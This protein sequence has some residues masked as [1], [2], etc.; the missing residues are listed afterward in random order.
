V[1]TSRAC[2][3]VTAITLPSGPRRIA[4]GSQRDLAGG[5]AGRKELVGLGRLGQRQRRLEMDA[6][7]PR[8]DG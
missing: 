2:A 8:R 6:E 1:A 4:L 7:S 3:A 5:V